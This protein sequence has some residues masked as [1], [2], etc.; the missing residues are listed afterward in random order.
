MPLTLPFSRRAAAVLAVLGAMLSFGAAS[1]LAAPAEVPCSDIGGGK[2]QCYFYVPG[3]GHSGGTAVKSSGGGVVGYLH[4]GYNWIICQQA[5]GE[6]SS[7]PYHNNTWGWTLSDGNTWGWV[8][9]VDARYSGTPDCGGAHG[10]P[11]G[12]PPP[13]ARR[14][15]PGARAGAVLGDRR[16]EVLLRLVH[17]GQRHRLR[18]ASPDRRRRHGRLPAPR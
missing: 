16:R 18:H 7:G 9:A 5:G 3:D 14:R 8:N 2:H 10:A 17:R 11:P 6:V 1:A 15:R 4:Q 13:A 12:G